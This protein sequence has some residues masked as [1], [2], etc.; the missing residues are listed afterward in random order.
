MT[1]GVLF[2]H[3]YL[4]PAEPLPLSSKM[5]ER[6]LAT[7]HNQFGHDATEVRF[8]VHQNVGVEVTW[9]TDFFR[10]ASDQDVLSAVTAIRNYAAEE[11]G[12]ASAENWIAAVK[13]IF[14]QEH[15]SYGITQLG[16]VRYR[17][18]HEF[19][20]NAAAAIS[21]LAKSRY[22]NALKLFESGQE[23]LSATQPDGKG[24]IRDTFFAA[25]NIFRLMFSDEPRLVASA[26]RNRLGPIL[27][28][29]YANDLAARGASSKQLKSFLE[30]V[31]A[32]HFYRHEPGT[33]APAQP[34]LELAVELVSVGAAFLRRLVALDTAD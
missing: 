26:A 28:G 29:K 13:K 9:W 31:E 12:D 30:W 18:D 11:W 7:V 6:L 14:E 2:S 15:A 10:K 32:V 1:E 33:E 24:A 4:R 21:V 20:R 23:K 8:A 5:R 16:E 27:Q 17:H 3:F 34:P 25:E 22:A 19:S